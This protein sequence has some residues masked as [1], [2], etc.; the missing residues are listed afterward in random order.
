MQDEGK[1]VELGVWWEWSG[2]EREKKVSPGE[3]REQKNGGPGGMEGRK[4]E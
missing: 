3:K 2:R 4:G 1:V